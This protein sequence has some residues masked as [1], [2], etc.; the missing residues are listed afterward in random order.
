MIR[1]EVSYRAIL[2]VAVMLVSLWAL[3]KLWPIILLILT[4]FIFH[5][6]LLPYV[7]WLVRKGLPR[8]PSVLLIPLANMG[9]LAGLSAPLV[10]AMGGRF[11][12]IQFGF[13]KDAQDTE[14][15][16]LVFGV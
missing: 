16:L 3:T 1:I 12:N 13:S 4:A 8:T 10:P 2:L 7:E 9:G 14:E 15:L 5:T 11:T 6:A